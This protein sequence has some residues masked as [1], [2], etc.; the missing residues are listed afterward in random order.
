MCVFARAGARACICVCEHAHVSKECSDPLVFA[1]GSACGSAAALSVD[2]PRGR[3]GFFHGRCLCTAPHLCTAWV[4][5]S[6]TCSLTGSKAGGSVLCVLYGIRSEAHASALLYMC[7]HGMGAHKSQHG[8][9]WEPQ[10]GSAW[11]QQHGC[12]SMGA[13]AWERVSH[14]P[15][16]LQELAA[17]GR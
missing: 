12:H 17:L 15:D 2:I 14:F 7:M 13:T 11:E 1:R 16:R 9:A 8:S 3:A 5:L 10:H 6:T 4:H